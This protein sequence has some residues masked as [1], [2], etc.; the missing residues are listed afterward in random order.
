MEANIDPIFHL[1]NMKVF[2]PGGRGKHGWLMKKQIRF[3]LAFLLLACLLS[4]CN[5]HAYEKFEGIS[6]I[7]PVGSPPADYL[8]WSPVDP[9]KILVTASSVGFRSAQVY[10]LDIATGDKQILIETESGDIWGESWSPDGRYILISIAADTEG[11]ERG[12]LRIWDT[13]DGSLEILLEGNRS[14]SADWSPD[15][16]KIAIITYKQIEGRLDSEYEVI[17]MDVNTRAT[18]VIYT[19]TDSESLGVPSWSPDGEQLVFSMGDSGDNDLYTL[20]VNTRQLVQITS[21]ESDEMVSIWS[22]DRDLIA[23]S[24]HRWGY[25]DTFSIHIVN[26]DGSCDVEIPYEFQ[27]ILLPTW[28]P[29]GTRLAFVGE[30]GIYTLDLAAVFGEDFYYSD[31]F[32]CQ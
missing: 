28:S 12:G 27:F 11:Y 22:S 2:A 1:N 25:E 3:Q 15:G 17:L 19:Y 9:D 20:D 32:P 29:D 6:Y 31:S 18:E 30:D 23:Y 7:A 16:E 10:I 24:E 21:S 14:Y 4:S 5:R 8:V 13:E 26:S